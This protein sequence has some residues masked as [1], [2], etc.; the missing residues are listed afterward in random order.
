MKQ[1]MALLWSLTRAVVTLPL[2]QESNLSNSVSHRV[3]CRTEVVN[4]LSRSL[5]T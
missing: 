1:I 2:L 4:H 3:K 5:E